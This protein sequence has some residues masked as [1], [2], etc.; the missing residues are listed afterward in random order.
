MQNTQR[1]REAEIQ[2]W[3]RESGL[4]GIDRNMASTTENAPKDGTEDPKL[5]VFEDDDEFEEFEN[6]GKGGKHLS[7]HWASWEIPRSRRSFFGSGFGFV[8]RKG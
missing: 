1:F 2:S 8:V 3:K 6:E 4:S 5:D 7:H